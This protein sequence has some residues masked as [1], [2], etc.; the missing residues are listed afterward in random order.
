MAVLRLR[1]LKFRLELPYFGNVPQS[2][3]L[4]DP[5]SYFALFLRLAGAKEKN[6]CQLRIAARV[7]YLGADVAEPTKPKGAIEMFYL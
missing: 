5:I 2:E 7:N 6:G 3:K 4:T 1:R